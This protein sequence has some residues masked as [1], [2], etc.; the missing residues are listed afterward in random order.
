MYRNFFVSVIIPALNEERSIALTINDLPAELDEI[1]VCDN[2]STDNT[3]EIAQSAGA[4]V[5]TERERGYGAACLKA[6]DSVDSRCDILLFI[7]ADYSD[8]PKEAPQ[9]LDPIVD[10]RADIVIGSRTTALESRKALTPV[11]RF[12]NLLATSLMRRLWDVA[13]TDLGPFRA[14]RYESYR[15]LQM[16]DRNFGWTVEMQIRAAKR[17]LRPCEIPVSYRERIGT[18]KIS[19]TISGSIKA[20]TKILYLITREALNDI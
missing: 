8:Y 1:V 11:A 12:G 13:Y 14:I 3:V 2:G 15:Q 4:K 9:L 20:G 6:I 17:R 19:G 7:D 16:R 18:S 5:V 10:N